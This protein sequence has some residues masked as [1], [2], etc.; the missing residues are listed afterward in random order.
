MREFAVATGLLFGAFVGV[1][2]GVATKNPG[3]GLFAF[4]LCLMEGIMLEL[5]LKKLRPR[6][7]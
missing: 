7:V 3:W 2:L 5:V 4:W 6:A 1:S